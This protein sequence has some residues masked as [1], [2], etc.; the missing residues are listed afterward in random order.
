MT[1]NYM[2]ELDDSNTLWNNL[3][4]DMSQNKKIL[5]LEKYK[6]IFYGN[7]KVV[8]LVRIDDEF[9][10]ESAIIGETE[11]NYNFYPIYLH[12]PKVGAPLEVIR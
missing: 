3:F 11:D 12:R 4:S 8:S 1:A 6:M 2:V 5:A 10:G 7:G 9:R